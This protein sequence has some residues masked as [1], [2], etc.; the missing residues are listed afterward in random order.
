MCYRMILTF[1][2]CLFSLSSYSAGLLSFENAWV[3]EAPP[4]AKNLAGYVSVKNIS[5]ESVSIVSLS[6]P[7]FEK[8]EMHVTTLK[9]GMMRMRQLGSLSLKSGEMVVFEPGGKHFMLK[10]P[11]KRIIS[12]LKVPIMVNLKSGEM[13]SIQ[14]EVRK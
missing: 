11:K 3:R 10:K 6:S 5:G 7:L 1:V 2:L 8:V 4:M 13:L 9:N 14:M 12:G